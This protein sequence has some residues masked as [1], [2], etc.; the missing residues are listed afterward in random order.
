MMSGLEM[1]CFTSTMN[2]IY[3]HAL[4]SFL[5][6]KAREKFLEKIT[7]AK[8]DIAQECYDYMSTSAAEKGT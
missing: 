3:L 2:L 8:E 7:A 6:F 1:L 4:W 5:F